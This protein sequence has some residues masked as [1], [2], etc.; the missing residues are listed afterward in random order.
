MKTVDPKCK[1][2]VLKWKKNSIKWK[3]KSNDSDS[4]WFSILA[5]EHE[6]ILN[7]CQSFLK[8]YRGSEGPTTQI[9]FVKHLLHKAKQQVFVL[10]RRKLKA[11]H[12]V[13]RLRRWEAPPLGRKPRQ[14]QTGEGRAAAVSSWVRGGGFCPVPWLLPWHEFQH[15]WSEV[16]RVFTGS[17]LLNVVL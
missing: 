4:T 12:E 5:G 14:Q 15:M 1:T 8:S 6:S 7:I 11:E 16:E 2:N 9:L 17:S 10:K 13:G 3:Y